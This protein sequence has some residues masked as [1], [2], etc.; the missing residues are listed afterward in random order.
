MLQYS[1]IRFGHENLSTACP[2]II[3][4]TKSFFE[5]SQGVRTRMELKRVKTDDMAAR[6][7]WKG[8]V[9]AAAAMW[10][11]GAIWYSSFSEAYKSANN[12][13]ANFEDAITPWVMLR[14]H[15][16][17]FVAVIITF[18]VEAHI[19]LAFQ[20]NSFAEAVRAGFWPWL[21]FVTSSTFINNSFQMKSIIATLIDCGYWLIG[22]TMGCCI[23]H[24]FSAP[25]KARTQ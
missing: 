13:P 17:S 12:L 22:L 7:S 23:L 18:H 21:G 9:C 10:M 3:F 14:I 4:R 25:N 5:K 8:I 20:V 16:A 1:C 24:A 15:G 2:L 19:L 11:F 6:I